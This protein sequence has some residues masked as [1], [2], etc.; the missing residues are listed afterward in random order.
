MMI[1]RTENHAHLQEGINHHDLSR[2]LGMFLSG[3]QLHSAVVVDQVSQQ[4]LEIGPLVQNKNQKKKKKISFQPE[5]IIS[6]VKKRPKALQN[7]IV[8]T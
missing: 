3:L 6:G 4:P 1:K 7:T 5:Y 8:L 2:Y